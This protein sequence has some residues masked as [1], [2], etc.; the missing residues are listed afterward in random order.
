LKREGRAVLPKRGYVASVTSWAKSWFKRNNNTE[1]DEDDTSTSRVEIT[2][3]MRKEFLETIEYHPSS[4]QAREQIPADW[5]DARV[6]FTMPLFSVRLSHIAG[7][8]CVVALREFTVLTNH[9]ARGV[10]LHAELGTV[11]ATALLHDRT[12]PLISMLDS[13]PLLSCYVG[14]DRNSYDLTLMVTPIE[15]RVD[16]A[17]LHAL[18]TMFV[19]HHTPSIQHIE[20]ATKYQLKRIGRRTRRH[21]ERQMRQAST[22]Q[23]RCDVDVALPRIVVARSTGDGAGCELMLDLGNIR[24]QHN[25]EC[26][27]S[28][29]NEF[30][31]VWERIQVTAVSTTH[32]G[33]SPHAHTVLQPITVTADVL[34]GTLPSA[35]QAR[36]K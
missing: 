25:E 19:R 11:E 26:A 8:L 13:A 23:V 10:Q 31:L 4:D 28:S 29:E 33:Q 36:V 32:L 15:V 5:I 22:L 34:L 1:D 27:N 14:S 16:T 3:E 9:C 12:T 21:V 20:I 2:D 6:E 24:A 18:M 30:N 7:P 17:I 35:A